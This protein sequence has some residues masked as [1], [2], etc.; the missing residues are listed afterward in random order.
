MQTELN[1]SILPETVNISILTGSVICEAPDN[2]KSKK[3]KLVDVGEK[4]GGAKKDKWKS[5]F[6]AISDLSD[7]NEREKYEYV[8]K[9]RIWPKP[10]YRKLKDGG[11]EIVAVYLC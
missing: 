6:L 8:K 5:R 7:M 11:V 10:D 2:I 9:D 4:I 3:N 1:F